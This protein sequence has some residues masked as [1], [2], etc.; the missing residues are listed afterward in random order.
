M[1]SFVEYFGICH[2]LLGCFRHHCI[3]NNFNNNRN[4]VCCTATMATTAKWYCGTM[5]DKWTQKV[6][7]P[8]SFCFAQNQT[9]GAVFRLAAT[10]FAYTYANLVACHCSTVLISSMEA[11]TPRQTTKEKGSKRSYV[12]NMLRLSLY[13]SLIQTAIDLIVWKWFDGNDTQPFKWNYKN[14]T[15][16][17][18]RFEY[19]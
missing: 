15:L 9:V 13:A 5:M 4:D 16:E 3:N 1:L 11:T 12:L 6:V 18:R 7:A 19:V 8:Q 14:A 17:N 2:S 10:L